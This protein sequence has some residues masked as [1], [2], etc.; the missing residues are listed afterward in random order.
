MKRRI[1]IFSGKFDPVHEGHISLC[2]ESI[3]RYNLEKVVILPEKIPRSKKPASNMSH[4][5]IL[6]DDVA[7]QYS[8][9]TVIK[10]EDKQFS[11]KD[12]LP[13]LQRMFKGAKLVLLMG[14]DVAYTL[15]YRWDH[16]EDLLRNTSL[17]IGLR[18]DDKERDIKQIIRKLES[19]YGEKV[20]A[21]IFQSPKPYIASSQMR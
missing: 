11:V 16:L 8:Q 5:V 21:E 2:L 19:K 10:L 13:K 3:R 17:I 20:S 14:S 6:L 12:T 1:G 4:R 15:L 7:R 18:N 9:L